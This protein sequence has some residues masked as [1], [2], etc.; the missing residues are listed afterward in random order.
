MAGTLGSS[1]YKCS[2]SFSFAS[3]PPLPFGLKREFQANGKTMVNVCIAEIHAGAISG[4][5]AD[6]AP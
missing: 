5:K 1:I 6:W 4:F 2:P 3:P